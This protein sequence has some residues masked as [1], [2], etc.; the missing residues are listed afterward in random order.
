[1]RGEMDRAARAGVGFL[2]A[3]GEDHGPAEGLRPHPAADW[4]AQTREQRL[5]LWLRSQGLTLT[6]LAAKVGVHKSAR[7]SGW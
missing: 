6:G 5:R 1:M 4:A 3:M 7:G 2:A